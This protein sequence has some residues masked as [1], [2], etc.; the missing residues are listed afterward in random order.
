MCRKEVKKR[1]LSVHSVV[2]MDAQIATVANML[3][4]NYKFYGFNGHLTEIVN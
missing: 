4:G 2:W 3:V 1:K